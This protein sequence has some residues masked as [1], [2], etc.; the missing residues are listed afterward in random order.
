MKRNIFIA[1]ILFVFSVLLTAGTL[2]ESGASLPGVYAGSSDWG[3]FDKDGDVDLL[4]TGEIIDTSGP[5]RIA[6]LYRND[7]GTL[8]KVDEFEGVYFGDAAWCDYDNDSDLDFVLTGL[9]NSDEELLAVYE[10][11]YPLGSFRKDDSQTE[12]VPVKYSRVAWGDYNND[13]MQDLVVTGMNGFGEASTIIYKNE[14]PGVKNVF[15]PDRTQS[16]LNV[17]KG[18]ITWI[19][20]DSDGDRDLIISGLD[21]SGFKAAKIFKNDPLGI[22]TED[23]TISANL[24]KLSFCNFA[25]GDIDDDGDPD[26]LVT[27]WKDGADGYSRWNAETMLLENEPTGVLKE[28][29]LNITNIVGPVAFADYDNDGDLDF[30]ISGRDEFNTLYGYIYKNDGSKVFSEDMTQTIAKLRDGFLSWADYDSDGDIDLC[31]GGIN[32]SE[33]RTTVI[34]DNTETNNLAPTAP[35]VLGTPVVTNNGVLFSWES[36]ADD[37][38]P[39]NLLTYNLRIGTSPGKGDVL[40]AEIPLMQG[41]AGVHQSFLL[42]KSLTKQTYYWSVQ[43]VDVQNKKSSFSQEQQFTVEVFVSSNQVIPDFQQVTQ[44]WGDY[45]NDGD[46]DMVMAGKDANES[47]RSILF[48]NTE[49]SITENRNVILYGFRYGDFAWGDYTNDGF[50]DLAYAGNSVRTEKISGVY[51]NSAG[52][53]FYHSTNSSV[54]AQVER[55]SLDWGDYDNDGDLDLVMMGNSGT[56]FI[57]KV[58]QNTNGVLSAAPGVYLAGYGNGKVLWL[59]YDSDG[60]LDILIT[61]ENNAGNNAFTIYRNISFGTFE[62]VETTGIADF[63]SSSMAY[64]D[65]DSDGDFDIVITGNTSSGIDIKVY[66][67]DNGTFSEA[68]VLPATAEGVMGGSVIFGD[69]DNDGDLDLVTAGFNGTSGILKTYKNNNGVYS[70]DDFKVLENNGLS[71]CDVKL[72]DYDGD[73]DLDLVAAGQHQTSLKAISIFYDNVEGI[74]HPNSPPDPPSLDSSSVDGNTATLSWNK[75]NDT[76]IDPTPSDALTY[77]LRVGTSPGAG[78]I[79]TGAYSYGFGRIGSEKQYILRNLESGIYYW[80]VKALDNGYAA[81][82]WA[83]EETFRIDTEKPEILSASV[84][85]SAVGISKATVVINFK[86]NF[87]MDLLQS[88]DVKAKLSDGSEVSV[89]E[90]SYDGKTWIGE[91]VIESSYSSGSATISVA[92]V[93][94]SQGNKMDPVAEAAGFTIDTE[95]PTVTPILPVEDQLGVSITTVL[96]ARFSEEMNPSS[97]SQEVFKLFRETEEISGDVSFSGDSIRFTPSE[98]LE[99]ETVYRAVI[100]AS[101]EDAVGNSMASDFSWTFKTASTVIA[102]DGGLLENEDGTVKIYFSPNS[103]SVD[104]EVA[105]NPPERVIADISTEVTYAGT[106]VRLGPSDT[107]VM[108]NKP[109]V[110]TLSYN[111]S[112][113]PPGTNVNRLTI[114]HLPLVGTPE[115]IGGSV[116]TQSKKVQ[117]S[118]EVLGTYG[119]FDDQT[120]PSDGKRIGDVSFSP[121]V[122][123]PKGGGA[124]PAKTM[125]NFKLASSMTITIDVYNSTGRFVTRLIEKRA[126]NQG[127]QSFEWDGRD[128]NGNL[129]PSGLYIVKIHGEGVTEIKTVGV[130][131]K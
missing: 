88:P 48:S 35:A 9:D 45:D 39:E 78:D 7:S 91:L 55:A 80:S 73:G 119:L 97:L 113:L 10:N 112:S 20:Y 71:F 8:T 1:C 2:N 68:D 117:T 62:K 22:L 65:Y 131:N 15:T 82:S 18:D 69:Y 90:V 58:Y 27:G 126:L 26:V 51:D 118:I 99:S 108:L 106:G 38:T 93:Y 30:A 70:E 115:R 25:V 46:P 105:I 103:L 104:R 116:N 24:P 32:A 11:E 130:L 123:T 79:V 75:G 49:T 52:T 77:V 66:K 92:N 83:V 107:D 29:S 28:H 5:L 95:L 109:A 17:C 127:A 23:K 36:G 60:D 96:K 12:L 61:G 128:G 110:L 87:E 85:P 72:V 42:N 120:T 129:C 43:T 21:V 13:G 3:D 100:L 34:Y 124:L 54:L 76:D 16:L 50:L 41:N 56:E 94:D 84:N 102:V 64:G 89:S 114:Y 19:D 63:F 53:G 122:F 81:S 86:E 101:V 74:L 14:K 98:R 40:S 44:E 67:N 31:M 59:D 47:M 57:T 33:S 111:E 121:R 4:L 6:W 37:T 125:I